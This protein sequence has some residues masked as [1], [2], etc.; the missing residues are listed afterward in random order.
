MTLFSVRRRQSGFSLIE[1]LLVL[2]I[3]VAISALWLNSLRRDNE[4]G[5]A[6]AAGEQ[7]K[8]VGQAL[9][10]YIAL[11]YDALISHT[12]G[13]DDCTSS[14]A[15][16][17]L[18][19]AN[20]GY[21]Q[22]VAATIVGAPGKRCTITSE[23]L[24]MNGLVPNSFSGR[25]SW[26]SDYTYQIIVT[27]STPN[28]VVDG[29]VVTAQPY[30]TGAT[31]RYDLLGE[32]MLAAGV[33]AGITRN[34]PG[35][36]EGYNGSWAEDD[37]RFT[38]LTDLGQ[39]AYRAGY[40]SQAYNVYLRRDGSL[41][42][43]GELDMDT[44]NIVGVGNIDATGRIL[45]ARNVITANSESALAFGPEAS[46]TA[47]IGTFGAG[48]AT[49]MTLRA[50]NTGK[51]SVQKMNGLMGDLE[52]S[53]VRAFGNIVGQGTLT[54]TGNTTLSQDLLVG[55]AFTANGN[56]GVLGNLDVTGTIH[57]GTRVSAGSG[58]TASRLENSA[59]YLN[60]G[61][62]ARG[63]LLS[64]ATIQLTPGTNLY[65]DANI[66]A[67]NMVANTS[68][69]VGGTMLFDSTLATVGAACANSPGGRTTVRRA[70]AGGELLQCAGGTWTPMGLVAANIVT[71]DGANTCT[72]PNAS[73]VD[74]P[75]VAACATG[76]KM[77]GGGYYQVSGPTRS[78]PVS[79]YK[80][81]AN[82]WS[83]YA[84]FND[85]YGVGTITAS[86]CWRAQAVCS[87]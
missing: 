16:C 38:N 36:A 63:L 2:G 69:D 62:T 43:S 82:A 7:A 29:M 27:G 50:G 37:T 34:A 28:W 67:T 26:G 76:F 13:A 53:G 47:T 73:P 40:G 84:G 51:V 60:T 55:G 64:G 57:S 22:C 24:R 9:N 65:T 81:G 83:I 44:H 39:L 21:R 46:P 77:I 19:A 32:A 86:T 10:A 18:N 1:L 15:G 59:L 30:T 25:N 79:S 41:P 6:R 33:D 56:A 14:S 68:L 35:R 31:V 5:Q 17:W 52:A 8:V 45:S 80:S 61:G 49:Q 75:S 66:T 70:S 12:P 87:R 78:G 71:V 74:A 72:V 54:V 3:S 20:P 85:P 42:M 11:R 4:R 58:A 48:A 23:T